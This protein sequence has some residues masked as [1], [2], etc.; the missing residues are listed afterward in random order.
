M[1]T[2]RTPERA[3]ILCLDNGG[4]HRLAVHDWRARRAPGKRPVLCVHGLTR[5]GRDFDVLADRLAADRRV[6]CPDVVGRGASD[7]LG[8]AE[9]YGNDR[10]MADLTCVLARMGTREVDWI[11]TSMGG[12]LGML[13]AAQP[14]TPV[15]RLVLNDVGP[16]VPREALRTIADDVGAD[17]HFPDFATAVAY[18]AT[19]HAGFGD[20]TDAQWRHLTRH[21]VRETSDGGYRLAYDPK[22]AAPFADRAQIT[23]ID[24]WSVWDAIACP[25]LVVR[26]AESP[27]LTV[28]TAARMQERGPGV[29]LMTVPDTGHAPALLD[30]DQ[31]DPIRDWLDAG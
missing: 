11:G 20:L 4:F 25:V 23:D 8:A 26:G 13:M 14:N 6:A 3:D 19:I 31:V 28:E 7:W 2:E 27:L 16:F 24:L 15:R 18:M 1:L 22:I 17:P 10:S 29:T 30:P 12:L 9:S 21:A 5:T